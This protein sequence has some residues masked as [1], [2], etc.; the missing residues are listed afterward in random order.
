MAYACLRSTNRLWQAYDGAPSENLYGTD[1]LSDFIELGYELF[2][3]R[4]KLKATFI[5]SDVFDLETPLNQLEGQ[6]GIVY[7]GSFFHLF[8]YESQKT[9]GLRIVRLLKAEPGVVLIGR[10]IGNIQ[11]GMYPKNASPGESQRYM[12]DSKTWRK[13][14]DD[15]GSETGTRWDV[16]AE[17]D[18]LGF[19]GRGS[20]Q[21]ALKLKEHMEYAGYRRLRFVVKRL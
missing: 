20:S 16:Q 2:C 1:L 10:N 7:A 11:P 5:P 9:V 13:M 3:D 17:M 15:I 19:E 8:D 14:W 4:D 12:H 6:M 21:D 18:D